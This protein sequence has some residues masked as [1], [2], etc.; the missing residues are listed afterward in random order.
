MDFGRSTLGIRAMSVLFSAGSSWQLSQIWTRISSNASRNRLCLV[1]RE[2][3]CLVIPNVVPQNGQSPRVGIRPFPTKRVRVQASE[4][5]QSAQLDLE[6]RLVANLQVKRTIGG[7]GSVP[8]KSVRM[9]G[10]WAN[11][12]GSFPHLLH[13]MHI[14]TSLHI[15]SFGLLSRTVSGSSRLL[16]DVLILWQCRKA[17]VLP[18]CPHLVPLAGEPTS[19]PD[20]LGDPGSGRASMDHIGESWRMILAMNFDEDRTP[21]AQPGVAGFDED[22]FLHYR[23]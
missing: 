20:F 11:V 17:V 14:R 8:Q 13:V 9:G 2:R 5:A 7:P 19:S 22:S 21:S 15:D 1:A 4:L 18:P 12:I 3:W 6:A 10:H 23:F 16:V